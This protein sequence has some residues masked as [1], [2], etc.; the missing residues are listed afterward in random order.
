MLCLRRRLNE[1]IILVKDGVVLAKI[2]VMKAHLHDAK[3][4]IEAPS[5][6]K[7]LR[8]ELADGMTFEIPAE[9]T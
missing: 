2:T 8:S 6:V 5:N 7:I 3:L 1:S 4:G 9:Q